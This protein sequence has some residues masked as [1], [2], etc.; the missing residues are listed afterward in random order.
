MRVRMKAD[1]SGD[2]NGRSWPQRGGEVDLPDDEGAALCA[3]GMAEPVVEDK[4]EKAVVPDG[5]VQTRTTAKKAPSKS[6]SGLTKKSVS[7]G[8]A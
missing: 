7:G 2:R 4:V 1:V 5:D 3:N 8:D 6:A